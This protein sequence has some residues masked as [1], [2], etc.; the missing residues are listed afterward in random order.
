[1]SE[2]VVLPVLSV[3]NPRDLGGYRGFEN[4]KIKKHRLLRTGNISKVTVQDQQFLL[5][6]GLKKIIDLRSPAECEINPD[7]TLAGVEHYQ[8]PLGIE[9][10]TSGGGS[11]IEENKAKYR[12]DQYAG[13]KMMCARYRKHILNKSSQDSFHQILQLIASQDQGAILYHC[14][15]G[16]DRTGL[17]TLLILHILGVDPETIRQDYLYSNYMLNEYRAVRDRRFKQ[18]GENDKFRAN[19][20]VLGSVSDAFLDTSLITINE[21]YGG[22]DAYLE[23]AVGITAQVQDDI[24]NKYLEK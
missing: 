4:R 6:Y 11:Q 15:E 16:K 19:M 22:L 17:V 8:L 9:D 1:M 14:S 10:N 21:V 23:Q 7:K 13:L 24:R 20:R 18:R 5:D 2:P 12:Q 3:R